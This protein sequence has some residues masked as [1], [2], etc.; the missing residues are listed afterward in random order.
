MLRESNSSFPTWAVWLMGLLTVL[1]AALLIL[2]I[3]L[4]VQAGQRQ[5]AIAQRQEVALA[6]ADAIDLQAQGNHNAALDAYKRVLQLEP[7]NDTAREGIQRVLAL[8]ATGPVADTAVATPALTPAATPNSSP[9][10]VDNSAASQFQS[11]RTAFDAGRWQEAVSQLLL[12]KQA[13]VDYE[14]TQV[15]DMLFAAYVNLAAERDNEDNLE[16]A[17]YLYDR[18]IELRSDAT[19]VQTERALIV[20]Y[21]DILTYFGADWERAI[22]LLEELYTQEPDY[23]DVADR[24]QTARVSYGDM[25]VTRA[26][27]CAAAE[28]FT[29]ASALAITPGLIVKRDDAQ[30]RCDAGD[31]LASG[32]LTGTL[33][34]NLATAGTPG[35]TAL[36]GTREPETTPAVVESAPP[37]GALPRGRLLYS[38]RDLTTG[39]N[40][41]LL[42][43]LGTNSASVLLQEEAMQPSLRNDGQRV[44]FRNVRSDMAGLTALDPATGLLL[45]FTQYAE[46]SLPSWNPQGN[47]VVFASNREGDRRWRIYATW[48]EANAETVNLGFG[49]APAWHPLNDLIV[50]RGC[51]ETGNAC[52]LWTMNGSGSDRRPL[53]AIQAD[54]R[55]AW[56]PNGRYVVFMSDG[57]DGNM[58]IY[59][60]DTTNGQMLR[61]TDSP[62][63]DG[64]PT[65]SPDSTW[66]AFV[67]NR[68]GAWKVWAM[69]ITG[70]AATVLTPING[71]LGN[72]TDQALQWVD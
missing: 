64:L 30:K 3:V 67:S 8:V 43:T 38:A 45:R 13:D 23:R 29:A 62:G 4:G 16:E 50:F 41:V 46:D 1:A 42:Q 52:G 53:T 63:L 10:I 15:R 26:D 17:L 12:V 28:Q 33:T 7:D 60:A 70:G 20:N 71:D 2:A 22:T 55:P 39:R 18:A 24:L 37:S 66:V 36:P 51:N 65:V 9:T 49:D 57:R 5:L 21:L 27:W 59:R 34:A 48:A 35:A 58:E 14:V 44:V 6:L 61:L 40:L 31:T 72:W 56:S 11:A 32:L 69:P 19:Q 68:D 54:T 47:R 25:L